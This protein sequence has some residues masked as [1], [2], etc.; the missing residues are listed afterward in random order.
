QGLGVFGM[1]ADAEFAVAA[2]YRAIHTSAFAEAKSLSSSVMPKAPLVLRLPNL[3]NRILA[4]DCVEEGRHL[5]WRFEGVN[6]LRARSISDKLPIPGRQ[7]AMTKPNHSVARHGAAPHRAVLRPTHWSC[8]KTLDQAFGHPPVVHGK[9][10]I[11]VHQRV[12]LGE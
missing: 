4:L 1:K 8:P 5:G 2:I 7:L 6:P 9:G 11:D 10:Q 3:G 12:G